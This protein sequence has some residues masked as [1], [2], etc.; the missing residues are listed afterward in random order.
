MRSVFAEPAPHPIAGILA[1]RAAPLVD[2]V[3]VAAAAWGGSILLTALHFQR[4]TLYA[5]PANVLI[6]PF[7]FA[8]LFASTLSAVFSLARLAPLAGAINACNGCFAWLAGWLA[9]F[10]AGLP[11]SQVMLPAPAAWFAQSDPAPRV[12]ALEIPRGGAAN[13]VMLPGGEAWLIDAGSVPA[14]RPV[15]E[16]ALHGVGVSRLGGLVVTHGDSYHAGGAAEAVEAFRPREVWIAPE[17]VD[18]YA[19]HRHRFAV[20]GSEIDPAITVL[21]P[22]PGERPGRAVAD[23][24][25]AVIRL[26]LNGWRLLLMADAGFEAEKWLLANSD[27]AAL[28]C[29]VL[30]KGRHADDF[31]GLP[32]FLLAAAP[33]VI[34][35]THAPFP[36]GEAIPS[37]WRM[38][39]ERAGI[40]LF[41]QSETGG[42][43]IECGDPLVIRATVGGMERRIDRQR[44][45]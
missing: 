22:P 32:E 34:V 7:V 6:S 37:E 5:I 36:P 26:D 11:G 40:T 23:D 10:F 20:A 17:A 43:A 9:S 35:A 3:A 29:D 25:A 2:S 21:F 28:R 45:P 1:W 41:D 14:Y 31:S 4:I 33:A 44:E 15:V 8:S 27:P 16:S 13:V 30:I 19:L 42:V 18:R 24:S 38:E 12:F 39:V